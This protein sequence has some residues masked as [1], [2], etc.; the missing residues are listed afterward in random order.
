MV[1]ENLCCLSCEEE[2]VKYSTKDL[3]PLAIYNAISR[4]M[5]Y[6]F[7]VAL[8]L[9]LLLLLFFFLLVLLVLVKILQKSTTQLLNKSFF[10]SNKFILDFVHL[11]GGIW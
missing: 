4:V 3:L 9:L 7:S 11:T 5:S 2:K 1:S 6:A 8:L 10:S